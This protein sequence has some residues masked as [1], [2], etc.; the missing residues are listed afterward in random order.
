MLAKIFFIFLASTVLYQLSVHCYHS[1]IQH[2]NKNNAKSVENALILHHPFIPHLHHNILIMQV[3]INILD[4]V[5]LCVSHYSF[6]YSVTNTFLRCYRSEAVA[7]SMKGHCLVN[8]Q[9]RHYIFQVA[10]GRL[11]G[12]NIFWQGSPFPSRATTTADTIG[13]L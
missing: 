9:I 11:I 4:V 5:S 8:L 12:K 13:I 6:S 3:S 2:I 1:N 7:G 10:I